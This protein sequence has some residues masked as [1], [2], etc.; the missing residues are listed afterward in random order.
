MDTGQDRITNLPGTDQVTGVQYAGY[1]PVPPVAGQ[2]DAQLFYWLAGPGNELD[3]C[4]P[5]VLWTNGGPGSPSFWGI[6]TENGPYAVADPGTAGTPPKLKPREKAWNNF[7]NYLV[8]EHPLGCTLS[9]ADSAA[10]VPN[11]PQD[12]SDQ[13]YAA[14]YNVLQRHGLTQAPLV[15]S[16][17]SYAG[18]YIPL[19][20][21]RILN[22]GQLTNFKGIVLGDSWIS[23]ETQLKSDTNYA[24]NND[25]VALI[26]DDQKA[27]LDASFTQYPGTYNGA[28]SGEVS[29]QARTWALDF[30][31]GQPTADGLPLYGLGTAIQW[32]AAINFGFVNPAS[33][34]KN[35]SYP[36]MTNIG[37]LKGKDPSFPHVLEYLNRSDVREALHA[38]TSPLFHTN[39]W[40]GSEP[41]WD[42]WNQSMPV[43][44]IVQTLL[45]DNP[46]FMV[47]VLSGLNDAKDCNWMGTRDWLM[48]DLQDSPEVGT[49]RESTPVP[50]HTGANEDGPVG[51]TEQGTGRLRWLRVENAGH[52]AV[53]DQPDLIFYITSRMD[54]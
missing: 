36:Y 44:D 4:L 48:H 35:I 43:F 13:Y 34:P 23:P 9:F 6:L 46:Q 7:V 5:V 22:D 12:G 14:L 30:A 31:T 11:T 53:M 3:P 25:T 18:T 38:P 26:T 29:S 15:L 37:K 20:A 32:L 28:M 40:G 45:D 8:I 39:S 50:W 1:V 27:A 54:L 2:P 24:R 42:D 49:F 21:Q 52:M 47:L 19:L 10:S 51:G 41:A 16:G 17:E 33:P